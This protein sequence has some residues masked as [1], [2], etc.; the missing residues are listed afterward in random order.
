MIEL[1]AE[2]QKDFTIIN[3]NI[4]GVA[5]PEMLKNISIPDISP[6]QGVILSGRA[7]VW[8]FCFLCHHF[9]P[10]QWVATHDPRL[11]GAVVVQTHYPDVSIGQI[12][13][14]GK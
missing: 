14:V 2:T 6:N 12:V 9:H 11:N 5:T 4:D 8:L 10:F 7:P 3:I 1:T 13:P